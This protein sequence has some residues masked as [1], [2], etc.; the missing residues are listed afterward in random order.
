M[1]ARL[2]SRKVFLTL[3]FIFILVGC[4]KSVVPNF[5]VLNSGANA[6][7]FVD[8]GMFDGN[9]PYLGNPAKTPA[10]A[11]FNSQLYLVSAGGWSG[12]INTYLYNGNDSVP[13]W[14]NNFGWSSPQQPTPGQAANP[15]LAIYEN[16]TL[17]TAFTE[18]NT[19]SFSGVSEVFVGS[20]NGSS[21]SYSAP[22][23]C[24]A[25]NCFN[26]AAGEAASFP[27][28]AASPVSSPGIAVLWSEASGPVSKV[29]GS[30][31]TDGMTWTQFGPLNTNAGST[32]VN[33]QVVYFSGQFYVAW[34]ENGIG[35]AGAYQI[36][37]ASSSDGVTFSN[38]NSDYNL[39]SL[40][41]SGAGNAAQPSLAVN[42]SH[43]YASWID[44]SSGTSRV[45]V[46]A[47]DGINNWAFA[48][49][50][51]L[52]VNSNFN[53]IATPKM[54]NGPDNNLYITWTELNSG[55]IP[56]VRVARFN[57]GNTW[58]ILNGGTST[59]LNFNASNNASAPSLTS[60]NGKVYSSWE[61]QGSQD[62]SRVMYL[63]LF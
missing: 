40:S 22:N 59:D 52:N 38:T 47:F 58:S 20:F 5:S 6:F 57:G 1:K 62:L 17:Y 16:T 34:S 13:G 56:Q 63:K 29:W 39:P 32:A 61:E 4:T 10:L 14:N 11:N 25:V 44:S 24:G 7:P 21:W 46:A 42:T 53:A 12:G 9:F 48:D 43:L 33:P 37:V 26:S 18:L 30:H 49:T 50:G 60:F 27:T 36:H 45:R 55:G 51:F 8:G 15:S 3:L 28:I 54:L 19:S 23:S 35:G 2:L 31:S 41:Q